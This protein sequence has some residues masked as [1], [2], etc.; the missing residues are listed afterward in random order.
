[1]VSLQVSHYT[2]I[3]TFPLCQVAITRLAYP[4]TSECIDSWDKTNYTDYIPTDGEDIKAGWNYTLAVG[5]IV[6]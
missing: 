4:Y 1:M 6:L 5:I 2:T 3:V